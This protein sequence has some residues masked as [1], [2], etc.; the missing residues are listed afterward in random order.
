MDE[1]VT[2]ETESL[3]ERSSGDKDGKCIGQG[4]YSW[5]HPDIRPMELRNIMKNLCQ[6]G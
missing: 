3:G 2:R 6:D 5:Y 1:I 4:L